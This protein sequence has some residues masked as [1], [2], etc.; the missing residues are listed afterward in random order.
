VK[1]LGHFVGHSDERD[2]GISFEY[3][4]NVARMFQW[5]GFGLEKV[6]GEWPIDLLRKACL[7]SLELQPP[8]ESKRLFGVGRKE[9]K[10][11]IGRWVEGIELIS[12][13]HIRMWRYP[14]DL[15][16]KLTRHC[17]ST[18]RIPPAL[19]QDDFSMQLEKV[20]RREGVLL[21]NECLGEAANYICAYLVT[22]MHLCDLRDEGVAI[23]RLHADFTGEHLTVVAAANF[24]QGERGSFA[25]FETKCRCDEWADPFILSHRFLTLEAP[26]DIGPDHKLTIIR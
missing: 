20:L 17:A 3:G 8:E 11:A 12:D 24:A 6:P 14:T 10:R 25:L 4:V 5:H 7:A 9:V 15:E 26:V 1:D 13:G 22:R 19:T 16:R 2:A 18:L 21:A 23:S